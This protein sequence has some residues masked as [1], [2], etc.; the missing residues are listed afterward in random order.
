MKITHLIA[1]VILLSST[2]VLAGQSPEA[3]HVFVISVQREVFYFKVDKEFLGA[4]I[5]VYDTQGVLLVT[6]K[7]IKRK[8]IIDFFQRAP[9]LYTIKIAKG[10]TVEEFECL[11]GIR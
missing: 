2:A 3:H 4:T 7:V 10:N 6:E 11:Y 5:E 8:M 1:L 9:G